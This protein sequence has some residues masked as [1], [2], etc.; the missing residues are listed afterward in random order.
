MKLIFE[1]NTELKWTI[2]VLKLKNS[3]ESAPNILIDNKK[4]VFRPNQPFFGYFGE[5]LKHIWGHHVIACWIVFSTYDACFEL[6]MRSRCAVTAL[7]KGFCS[8][9]IPALSILILRVSSILPAS[10]SLTIVSFAPSKLLKVI[11]QIPNPPEMKT[12]FPKSLTKAALWSKKW[13]L[14]ISQTTYSKTLSTHDRRL[15]YSLEKM[16][17]FVILSMAAFATPHPVEPAINVL[18]TQETRG[19]K[20]AKNRI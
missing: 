17:A 15:F 4:V 18:S 14:K 2:S 1:A 19:K 10:P 6:T 8:S 7:N 13:W 11:C 20:Q 3:H 9:F 5:F 16:L 12:F